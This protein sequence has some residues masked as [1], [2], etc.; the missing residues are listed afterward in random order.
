MAD[1]AM[2]QHKPPERL[3]QKGELFAVG[4]K[5]RARDGKTA[6]CRPAVVMAIQGDGMTVQWV[7]DDGPGAFANCLLSRCAELVPTVDMVTGLPRSMV[8]P[9]EGQPKSSLQD[10]I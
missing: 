8:L 2:R 9:P 1:H 3:G 7:G 5:V 6:N 10:G 4:D